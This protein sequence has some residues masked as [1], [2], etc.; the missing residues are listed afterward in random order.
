MR[1]AGNN[2]PTDDRTGT[3]PVW[4]LVVRVG[5]WSLVLLIPTAWYS[6]GRLDKLHEWCG[7]LIL[8]ILMLRILWGFVGSRHARFADFVYAPGE[9][10]EFL[11]ATITLRARRYIGHNPA[12]GAMVITLIIVLLVVV[13]SGYFMTTDAG[14]GEEWVSEL[15]ETSVNLV[16]LL[17]ALHVLGVFVASLEHREN[18][19]RAMITGRKIAKQR[20]TGKHPGEKQE[21][22]SLY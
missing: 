4:D 9:V 22:Q 15:H 8:G 6:A 12:G 14:W 13:S 18:L 1:A 7:Y 19:V 20:N 21:R 16:W 5:H 11:R 2:L 17:V 3:V 10:L